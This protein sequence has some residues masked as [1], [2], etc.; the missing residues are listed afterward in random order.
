M[1]S[2]H[3]F[4]WGSVCSCQL[5]LHMNIGLDKIKNKNLPGTEFIG[6]KFDSENLGESNSCRWRIRHKIVT[7]S[8]QPCS[9]RLSK[10]MVDVKI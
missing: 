6:L 8:L 7:D 4:Q 2:K 3:H 5:N 10:L 9:N 1:K